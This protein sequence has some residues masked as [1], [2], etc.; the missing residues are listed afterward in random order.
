M[1]LLDLASNIFYSDLLETSDT[2]V[3]KIL[4]WL[5]AHI[6]D[7]NIRLST[8]IVIAGNDASPELTDAQAAVYIVI[9]LYN[10]YIRQMN[11]SM[12]AAQ[13]SV[14]EVGEGDSTVRYVNKNEIAKNFRGLAA[15]TLANL[16]K[17]C[18]E[19]KQNTALPVSLNNPYLMPFW[20]SFLYTKQPDN[21]QIPDS[22]VPINYE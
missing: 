8:K 9:Y 18:L 5:I 11:A 14:I 15:D 10:Y 16:N 2:S 22:V 3:V 19:Y 12:G 21:Q 17:V 4:S 7:L 1:K 6:G 13:F 20:S